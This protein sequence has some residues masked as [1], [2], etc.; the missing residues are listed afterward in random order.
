MPQPQTQ[1]RRPRVRFD[2]SRARLYEM[3]MI[4]HGWET[5]EALHRFRWLTSWQVAKLLFLGRPNL[6]GAPRGEAAARKAANER[7]LRRLKDRQLVETRQAMLTHRHTWRRQE[8]NVL[9]RS[10]HLLLSD[11]LRA[12]GVTPPEWDSERA[13]IA[14]ELLDHQLA[15]ND[16]GIALA[17]SAELSRRDAG[18]VDRRHRRAP[19]RRA[20]ERQPRG[21][22]RGGAGAHPQR[23]AAGPHRGRSRDGAG[24]LAR[25]ELVVDQDGPVRAV[26]SSGV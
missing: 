23:S 17:R 24:H 6:G 3:G 15:L 11:Q 7:C 26:P 18:G 8:Y 25:A 4:Q 22:G 12:R 2:P 14:P 10:G 13:A 16:V 9:T 5:L 1:P 19:R 21:P 20:T